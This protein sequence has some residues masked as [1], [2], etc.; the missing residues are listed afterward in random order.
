[1]SLKQAEIN[2]DEI[3][4]YVKEYLRYWDLNSSL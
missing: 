2:H 1:M 4:E 3:H